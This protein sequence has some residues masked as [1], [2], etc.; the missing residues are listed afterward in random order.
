MSDYKKFIGEYK[1]SPVE[2]FEKWFKEAVA[3]EENGPAFTLS[4]VDSEGLPNARTLLLKEVLD[5]K[6]LFFTNYDSVKASEIENNPKVAMTF[7]WHRLGK[8][9]RIRGSIS[10]CDS[11]ISKKY[12]H[13]RALE[14]QVASFISKQSSSIEDRS[15]LEQEYNAGLD[16]YKDEVPYPENWGGYLVDIQEITF[17]IY[18]EFRLND[19][20]QFIKKG[21]EWHSLR[22]YP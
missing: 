9:V 22:L 19:R 1:D 16:R 11:Q 12:F 10:K 13:S 4:T 17:F 5:F 21:N 2:I 15:K 8:Q 18:G 20:F 3:T 14:S 7:Y 6:P